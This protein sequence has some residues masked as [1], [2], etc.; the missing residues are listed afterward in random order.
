TLFVEYIGYPLFSGVKFSDVPINPHITKFQFVLSFAVDYTA[1]SP[2]TSTNG[3]F[4]VF[5]DSSILGPD[6]ISAIKSSHPNVRVAVSLGGASVGSNTVQFQ[7]A[8]V[9]S[10]VSN[11]VTSLTRII[12]RYN[13]DG[14]D[15]DYEH[16]QNTDKNTFAECIGRLITTLKKNGVISFASISPFPSVDEYYLALFNEYKNAINHINYQ[17][18]AYDSSTSVDKFLGYYNNAASKYKGGNVLISFSTGPHPGGLPVDKGFFDAATSLKNKGKLHGIAV[19]TADTSKS[20]DFRYE[21]EAQAF[22]VS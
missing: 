3:K 2:H 10:W 21:E 18:K 12:Q 15:I 20:S 14:I 19:W 7:A 9:D 13:L 8:S 4:N 5:W 16:F 22:L 11:A 6:Q 17:F 1:S